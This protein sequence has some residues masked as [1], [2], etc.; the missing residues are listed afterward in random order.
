MRLFCEDGDAKLVL[1]LLT[2]VV[3]PVSAKEDEV[4][5]SGLAFCLLELRDFDLGICALGGDWMLLVSWTIWKSTASVLLEFFNS[6]RGTGL[7]GWSSPD[8]FFF[9]FRKGFVEALASGEGGGK[10]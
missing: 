7:G 10:S 5:R 2:S 1:L 3:E 6:S 4:C 8:C 9:P